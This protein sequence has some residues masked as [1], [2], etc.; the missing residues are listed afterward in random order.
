MKFIICIKILIFRYGVFI[1]LRVKYYNLCNFKHANYI[2]IRTIL[3]Y[4]ICKIIR[5]RKV[6]EI[7]N[8]E[9]Y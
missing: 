2:F 7:L 6:K 4:Q 1:I 5:F 9:Y 8:I 3:G